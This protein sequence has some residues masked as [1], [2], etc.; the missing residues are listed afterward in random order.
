MTP[1]E[2]KRNMFL[3]ACFVSLDEEVRTKA[4]KD[5]LAHGPSVWH[6]YV[7][8]MKEKGF[9]SFFAHLVISTCLVSKGEI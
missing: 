5:V 6:K 7:Q 1:F 4:P 8:V 3:A 9:Y 2:T